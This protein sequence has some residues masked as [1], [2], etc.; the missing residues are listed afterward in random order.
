MPSAP[1]AILQ[2]KAGRIPTRFTTR[3]LWNREPEGLLC[4][5]EPAQTS[6]QSADSTP[7]SG[8]GTV[9][10]ELSLEVCFQGIFSSSFPFPASG[11]AHGRHESSISILCAPESGELSL[12]PC[13]G[14][15]GRIGGGQKTAMTMA[16]T[17]S[18]HL[19]EQ[20]MTSVLTVSR[21]SK[22]RL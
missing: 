2:K 8:E 22:V 6:R 3:S 21:M 12:L 14:C 4:L 5:L 1:P 18:G 13:H 9:S 15:S 19:C 11:G 10:S 20:S 16:A 17:A 7:G